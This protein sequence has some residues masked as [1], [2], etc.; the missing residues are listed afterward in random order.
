MELNYSNYREIEH[1][2]F[3]IK[4]Y[5][6]TTEHAQEYGY[7]ST[8]PLFLKDLYVDVCKRNKGYGKQLL[9]MVEDFAKS[10]NCDLIFGHIPQ[11]AGFNQ[12]ERPNYETDRTSIKYWLH[13]KGYAVNPENFDFHKVMINDNKVKYFGGLGFDHCSEKGNYEVI[14][15]YE[16]KLFNNL[17]EARNYYL[18]LKGEKAIW[19]LDNNELIDSWYLI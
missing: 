7:T 9:E 19:D 4:I 15:Q 6:T 11:D 10:N 18:S 13:R 1:D 14:T 17:T 3:R 2:G 8:N 12:D 16:N 5:C